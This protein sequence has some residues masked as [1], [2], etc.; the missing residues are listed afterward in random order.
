VACNIT[1]NNVNLLL[2]F[3]VR[4]MDIVECEYHV[5]L[6]CHRF[7][8]IRQNYLFNWYRSSRNLQGFINILSSENDYALYKTAICIEKLLRCSQ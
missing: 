8:E 7:N 6:E 3:F 1:G 2:N 5:L 4:R